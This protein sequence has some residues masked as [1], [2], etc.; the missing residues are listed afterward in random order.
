MQEK[1]F[2]RA[3]IVLD[4]LRH[5][6]GFKTYGQLAAFLEV[7]QN[8][9]SSW[10]GRDSLDEDLIYRKCDGINY[11]WLKTAKGEMWRDEQKAYDA[12]G[13]VREAY[14]GE[15]RQKGNVIAVHPPLTPGEKELLEALREFPEVREAMEAFIRLPKRKQIIYLGKLLEEIDRLEERKLA[16]SAE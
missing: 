5:H 6:Y 16:N 10:I 15:T 12:V 7:K 13:K 11:D 14:G 1:K 2:T 8:T 3:K 4:A 9:L